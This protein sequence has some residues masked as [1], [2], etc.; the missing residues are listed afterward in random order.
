MNY[1]SDYLN[2]GACSNRIILFLSSPETK[3]PEKESNRKKLAHF[4][5][6]IF[7]FPIQCIVSS[8]N[9]VDNAILVWYN[10]KKN[11]ESGMKARLKQFWLVVVNEISIDRKLAHFPMNVFD[12]VV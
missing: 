1:K 8:I 7:T 11:K 9:N 4:K 2:A 12:G 6:S 3:Q 10:T 5:W